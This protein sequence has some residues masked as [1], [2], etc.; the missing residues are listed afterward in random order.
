MPIVIKCAAVAAVSC[1][2]LLLLLQRLVLLGSSIGFHY[3]ASK[4][5][6]LSSFVVYPFD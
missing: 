4:Q 2:L 3:G 1:A 6:H 5:M